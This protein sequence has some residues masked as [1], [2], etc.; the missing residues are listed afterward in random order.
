[1]GQKMTWDEMK[2]AFPNEWVAVVNYI[3]DDS[4]E[5]EGEV[6]AHFDDKDVFYG[7][8]KNLV[9]R[10]GDIAMRYTGERIKNAEVP[11]L[12]RISHTA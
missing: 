8:L 6:V 11:L 10:Y 12:W 1:M 9:P 7:E 3:P 5:V 2:K 4:G